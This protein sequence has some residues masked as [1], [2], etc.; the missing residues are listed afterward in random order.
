[1]ERYEIRPC[2]NHTSKGEVLAREGMVIWIVL[3][4]LEKKE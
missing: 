2:G 1:M 4:L 3:C